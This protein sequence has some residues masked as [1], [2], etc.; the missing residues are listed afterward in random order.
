MSELNNKQ[1]NNNNF[2]VEWK[3][4]RDADNFWVMDLSHYPKPIT[5]LDYSF[6]V[7][8]MFDA[9]AKVQEEEGY[10][11]RVYCRHINTYLYISS[12]Y[13]CE[14]DQAEALLKPYYEK[15][16]QVIRDLDKFW[17]NDWL[18]KLKDHI[19][20]W[21]N[22]DLKKASEQKLLE[23]LIETVERLEDSQKIHARLLT[24]VMLSMYYFNQMYHDLFPDS[25]RTEAYE[26]LTGFETEFTKSDQQIWILSR[27]AIQSVEIKKILI[28]T[29]SANVFNR[30]SESS[31]GKI[32]LNDLNKYLQE[33]GKQT[34]NS[35]LSKPF[36]IEDPEPVIKTLQHYVNQPE[37]EDPS[38]QLKKAIEQSEKREAEIRKKLSR[39]PNPIVKKFESTLKAARTGSMIMTNHTHWL[40][41][42]TTCEARLV[43]LE[44]GHRLAKAGAI[45]ERDD[46]FYLRLEELQK[47]LKQF[48]EVTIHSKTIDE[49]RNMENRFAK[50][51]PPPFLGIPPTQFPND[52]ILFAFMEVTGTPEPP[53]PDLPKNQI[54]GKP[55]SSGKVRGIAR[56]IHD[57]SEANKLNPGDILITDFTLPPW[58]T[59]FARISAVVTNS[60][61][62]LSHSAIVAREFRIPAIVGTGIA[63]SVIKDG[64]TIE[65]DGDNGVV[66]IIETS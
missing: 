41:N 1:S 19:A 54:K 13:K 2:P 53:S 31:E 36:F 38:I 44:I 29:D 3:N 33:Y 23:H 22:F 26:L 63:T 60:G 25:D 65:V 45:K 57:L 16:D 34:D 47:I 32:F 12:I 11:G 6:L 9:T 28:D 48:P 27:Q 56:V 58:T 14:I 17:E 39:Y 50:I 35:V 24:P 55:A 18:P 43:I 20:F 37:H 46:V 7:T 15:M 66:N 21:N 5:P 62:M 8:K 4:P 51:Q 64:Q 52:P 49:R 42:Q 30:L 10:P 61:G 59:L 40:D